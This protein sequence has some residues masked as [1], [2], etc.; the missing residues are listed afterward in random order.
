MV[1]ILHGMIGESPSWKMTFG[2]RFEGVEG[3]M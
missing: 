2:Q 1:A 3:A